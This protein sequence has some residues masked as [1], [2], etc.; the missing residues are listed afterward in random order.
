MIYLLLES[1]RDWLIRHELWS[2]CRVFTYVEFRAILSIIFGFAFVLFLGK[3]TIHWLLRMKFRDQPEFYNADLN[4]LMKNKARTPTMGGVL[5]VGAIAADAILL[6]DLTNYYVLMAL[7]CLVWLSCVGLVDDYLKLT[8]ARRGRGTREG[9]YFWEKL[10]F[11]LALAV[12]LGLFIHHQGEYG[13][14]SREIA[15]MTHCV[16]L[17]L[18]KTWV[19]IAHKWVP[20][21]SLIVLGPWAFV[22]VTTIVITG[23]SNAV[24][25]TDGMDGL[26]SGIMTIVAFSFMILALIA[27]VE[28][29]SVNW[30]KTLLVP[31]IPQSA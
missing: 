8:A 10:V 2:Y 7:L 16:N 12:L 17:P 4:E 24:N 23:A 30:A 1:Q 11:Q 9:L 3:R 18:A 22:L 15:Q 5:I 13:S 27:G 26:A 21:P 25:L 29:G 19:S 28:Y 14:P 20:S 31:Y 6:A